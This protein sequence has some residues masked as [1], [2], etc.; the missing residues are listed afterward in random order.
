MASLREGY[1]GGGV[2]VIIIAGSELSIGVVPP[3]PYCHVWL[4][5]GTGVPYASSYC[6]EVPASRHHRGTMR[7]VADIEA[8]NVTMADLPRVVLTPC[9]DIAG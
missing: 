5:Y 1:F 8:A 2:P 9:I 7:L 4:G 3:A 6:H